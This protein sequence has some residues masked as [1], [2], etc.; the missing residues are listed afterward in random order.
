[1][2]AAPAG[3]YQN[4]RT[5]SW[6][7]RCLSNRPHIGRLEIRHRASVFPGLSPVNR[8]LRRG[9]GVILRRERRR[10][11]PG[12]L[13]GGADV[14][15]GRVWSARSLLPLWL[16]PNVRKRQQAARTP[17]ASRQRALLIRQA[18]ALVTAFGPFGCGIDG[19]SE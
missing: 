13:A 1:M 3:H 8:K 7:E 9:G 16:G 15:R 11:A 17:N 10:G 5:G 18:V 2:P 12:K 6:C 19:R 4:T 14:P